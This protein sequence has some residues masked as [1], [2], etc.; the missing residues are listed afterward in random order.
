MITAW[1]GNGI[2]VN[3]VKMMIDEVYEVDPTA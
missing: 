1:T 3:V 2:H